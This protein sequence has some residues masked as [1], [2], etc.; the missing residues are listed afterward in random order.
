MP[1]TVQRLQRICQDR[2]IQ[3]DVTGDLEYL[4]ALV[5]ERDKQ[6]KEIVPKEVQGALRVLW[7]DQSENTQTVRNYIEKLLFS[8]DS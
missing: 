3:F 2:S 5:L 8:P 1:I 7:Q 6:F 4:Q